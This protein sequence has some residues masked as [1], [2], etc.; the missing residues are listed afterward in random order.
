MFCNKCGN[1]IQEGTKFCNN[2]GNPLQVQK[3]HMQDMDLNTN[4][5]ARNNGNVD[6]TI[7][8]K[9]LSLSAITEKLSKIFAKFMAGSMKTKCVAI[10]I[11]AALIGGSVA[12]Y[13]FLHTDQMII[14]R[15]FSNTVDAI[16]GD[17]LKNLETIPAYS[18]FKN[19]QKNIYYIETKIEIEDMYATTEMMCNFPDTEFEV[20]AD[21]MGIEAA[22][23]KISE[24]HMTIEGPFFNDTYGV[25]IA[26]LIK[27]ISTGEN[28]DEL[29]KVMEGLQDVTK[30]VTKKQIFAYFKELDIE[31][32]KE[33]IKIDSNR[34]NATVYEFEIEGKEVA[35]LVEDIYE[36]VMETDEAT[37]YI[38]MLEDFV[39]EYE[40]MDLEESIEDIVEEI[41]E[42][43]VFE[44]E[45][46]DDM[47]MVLYIYK[48]IIVKLE[49]NSNDSIFCI[50]LNSVKNVLEEI[51]VTDNRTVVTFENTCEDDEY[52]LE[53]S[54]NYGE[55]ISFEYDGNDDKNNAVIFVDGFEYEFTMTEPTKDEF[56]FEM[57]ILDSYNNMSISLESEK[58]KISGYKFT[59][60]TD[61]TDILEMIEDSGMYAFY[62]IFSELAHVML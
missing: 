8:N 14:I 11:A 41:V 53:M 16:Q 42:E 54:T 59:Q 58:G 31:K 45:Y 33:T 50:E 12:T 46:M 52:V 22:T 62:S 47:D 38:S 25:D 37:N 29:Q 56:F 57:E 34:V 4:D 60:D 43:I 24:D 30:E 19:M 17:F 7:I 27:K 20:I 35:D 32:S 10:V 2:C 21:L 39:E 26:N 36:E 15:S 40:Q 13:A 44:L 61:Y 5:I 18:H 3:Q 51:V 28:I 1:K 55:S 23:A 6:Y 49:I 9:Q 48:G